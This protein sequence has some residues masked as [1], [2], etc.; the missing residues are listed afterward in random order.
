MEAG[1]ALFDDAV[2]IFSFTIQ[3]AERGLHFLQI[4]MNGT[5]VRCR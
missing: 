1:T 5:E 2:G 4:Q 3:T